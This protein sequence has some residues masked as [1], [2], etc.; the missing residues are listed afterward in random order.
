MPVQGFPDPTLHPEDTRQAA[1]NLRLIADFALP[2]DDA[3]EL[4]TSSELIP[5]QRRLFRAALRSPGVWRRLCRM[6]L[7]S[8]LEGDPA[9]WYEDQFKG[10]DM[11][12]VLDAVLPELTPADRSWWIGLRDTEPEA[13][14][15]YLDPLFG[16][17]R[18]VLLSVKIVDIDTGESVPAIFARQDA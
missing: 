10:P 7:V 9:R 3:E 18:S 2:S 17:I 16:E 6:A 1:V 15:F 5:E 4:L 12:Q 11:D 13:L 8:E 14:I